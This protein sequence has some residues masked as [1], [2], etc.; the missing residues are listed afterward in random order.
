M[1]TVAVVPA[2]TANIHQQQQEEKEQKDDEE[3]EEK[4]S[5]SFENNYHL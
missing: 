5:H 2:R 1:P 4:Y 3:E